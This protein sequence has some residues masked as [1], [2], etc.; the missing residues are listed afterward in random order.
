METYSEEQTRT[1]V[2]RTLHVTL[3]RR[4]SLPPIQR[5]AQSQVRTRSARHRRAV[6]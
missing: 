5:P 1:S 4:P 3:Q 2:Q 6:L